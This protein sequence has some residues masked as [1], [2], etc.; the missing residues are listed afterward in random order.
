MSA[1]TRFV[2]C[3]NCLAGQKRL[4]THMHTPQQ[5]QQKGGGGGGGGETE[6]FLAIEKNS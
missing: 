3:E 5:Q 2:L 4:H 1:S 6:E